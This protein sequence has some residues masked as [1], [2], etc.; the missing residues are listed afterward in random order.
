VSDRQKVWIAV[1]TS[2]N[3]RHELAMALIT[4]SHDDRYD[5]EFHFSFARPIPSN[6]CQI[7]KHFLASDADWLAMID[8]DVWPYRNLLDLVEAD[9]DVIVFPT[10]I[11]R[12]RVP[13]PP[14][15]SNITPLNGNRVDLSEAPLV[16][17][18]RGGGSAMLLSRR[19]LEGIPP[20]PFAYDFDADGVTTCDEDIYFCDK[21]RAAGF[22]IWAAYSHPC[23]HVKEIDLVD[24]HNRV[25]EWDY[26]LETV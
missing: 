5:L 8:S 18:A 24:V 23:G 21:A 17:V 19:V 16:E 11:W 26:A 10:P 13:E 3:V 14:I 4:M 25:K 12:A 15:V 1:L 7:V 22:A 2:G 9:E 6:R 20:P